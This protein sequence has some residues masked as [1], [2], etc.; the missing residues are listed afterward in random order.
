MHTKVINFFGGPGSG[1]STTALGV[2][3][4]LKANGIIAEYVSEFPKE[5]VWAGELHLLSDQMPIAREQFRRQNI[6]K[7]KVEFIVTDCPLV[8]QLPY[9][10]DH[11]DDP[12]EQKRCEDE[13]LAGWN[14]FENMNI[15]IQ[16]D[17]PFQQAGRAH[18]EEQS[19]EKDR[20]LK[21][22]L[23]TRHYKYC[24]TRSTIA[25]P[26]TIDFVNVAFDKQIKLPH[27]GDVEVD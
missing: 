10:L 21:E 3:S 6:L 25:I 15:F 13:V 27:Y 18:N 12:E 5:I 8:L 11:I 17:K 23:E 4:I 19:R 22:L 14:Q 1:K 20:Q 16:R 26:E 24:L 7:G 9:I 2:T